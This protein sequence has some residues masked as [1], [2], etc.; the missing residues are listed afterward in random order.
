[1]TICKINIAD[2]QYENWELVEGGSLK[3]ID[4]KLKEDPLHYKLLNQDIFNYENDELVMMHSTTRSMKCIPGVLVL[5]GNKMYG[6]I[7]R[8]RYY[9]RVVPDDRRL[10]EFLMAYS[11]KIG[12]EKKQKNKYIVFKFKEWTG[13]HPICTNVQ[14]IGDIGVLEN[15][16]EYQLYC[17]SLYASIQD[18]TKKTIRELKLKSE[19]SYIEEIKK[20]YEVEDREK[21][22]VITI[23]P[24]L[25]K[26]FDDGLSIMDKGDTVLLSI[27]ISNVSF[28]MDAM[29]LWDSFTN[30]IATIYLPD[31]KRPMLPTVLSDALCSLQENRYRFAITLDILLDKETSEIKE[32]KI[33]NA[34]IKVRKNLRYDTE[35]QENDI[36]YKKIFKLVKKMNRK[37][38]YVDQIDNSH[39]VVAYT[40][41]LMNYIIAQ[42]FVEKETGIFRTAKLKDFESPTNVP[43][44]VKKFLKMW[45][46]FGGKYVKY[47]NVSGHEMLK[48]DAYVHITSPIRRLVDLLNIIELQDVLG[49]CGLSMGASKFYKR[50]TNKEKFEYINVTMR[51]IRKVQNDCALLN[52]CV[53]DKSVI[54]KEHNGFIFDKI[55]RNDALFQYMVYFPEMKMVNRFTSR[56]DKVNLSKQ[57]FKLFIFMDEIRLRE[58]IRIEVI[59]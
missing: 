17:K 48:L 1:M 12:F 35:E 11:P 2:R 43:D 14:T 26:D 36:D 16:Y 28:W 10:P 29:G 55:K 15:F 3:K 53:T 13:K 59:D 21:W 52:I 6:K 40:M 44:E 31:R 41:I 56:Y 32:T 34:C 27:Y 57:K 42:K 33:V 23:D 22:S 30:R 46:S 37:Y 19:E 54:E 45:N 24:T 8:N 7:K 5:E 51:S 38:K 50:W 25:S 39:D 47:E 20:R 49:L 4:L 9:Y 18:F 58:K